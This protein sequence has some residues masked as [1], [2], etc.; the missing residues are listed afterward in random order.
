MAHHTKNPDEEGG[1]T[2]L[3]IG[4]LEHYSKRSEL[5]FAA[6]F[7]VNI[8]SDFS[9]SQGILKEVERILVEWCDA[10]G[11]PSE[12]SNIE[13]SGQVVLCEGQP[14]GE[15]SEAIVPFL[16]EPVFNLVLEKFYCDH[17][18]TPFATSVLGIQSEVAAWRVALIEGLSS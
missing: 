1:I 14:I 5:D 10:N 7:V 16:H 8:F 4:T 18:G 6:D 2:V 11:L 3:E 13:I 9:V 12:Y 17:H 15:I